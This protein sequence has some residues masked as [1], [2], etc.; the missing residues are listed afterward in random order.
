MLVDKQ[1]NFLTQRQYP[2][3]AQ[4]HTRITDQSLIVSTLDPHQLE[5][6]LEA[7]DSNRIDVQIWSDSCSAALVSDRASRWFSDFLEVECA[8][9][10]LPDSET[11]TVDPAFTPSRQIVGF[12]DGFP[13]LVLSLASIDLLNSQLQDKVSINRFRANI[14]IDGCDAHAEDTWASISVNDIGIL[15]AKPCS[16]CV[17]PSIHQQSA[18]KHPVILKTLAQYR[19]RNGKVIMGQNGLHCCNGHVSVG[20]EITFIKK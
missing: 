10:F 17:I 8:L 16:R 3:M 1:G 7:D 5:I 12:A 20:Q 6:P 4:I 15:L 13:L 14:I 19:R 9:V 2:K 11:R 18:E